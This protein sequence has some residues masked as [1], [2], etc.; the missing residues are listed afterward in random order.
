MIAIPAIDLR[1]GACVH[2][3]GGSYA[4]ERVRLDPPLAGARPVAGTP[5][6]VPFDPGPIFPAGG[7]GGGAVAAAAEVEAGR[8]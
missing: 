8:R 7:R 2:L 5:G 4:D 1:D 3:I 6:W